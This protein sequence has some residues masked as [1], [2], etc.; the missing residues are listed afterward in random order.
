MHTASKY[1]CNADNNDSQGGGGDDEDGGKE[2]DDNNVSCP[3]VPIPFDDRE[4]CLADGLQAAMMDAD[5]TICS[6]GWWG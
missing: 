3:T 6:V 1:G 5:G 2:E 4:D